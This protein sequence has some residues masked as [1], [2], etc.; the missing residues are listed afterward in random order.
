M[1]MKTKYEDNTTEEMD[2][3][4]MLISRT[5]EEVAHEWGDDTSLVEREQTHVYTDMDAA[6][7]AFHEVLNEEANH[8]SK[9]DESFQHRDKEE[10]DSVFESEAGYDDVQRLEAALY[11]QHLLGRGED[12]P[13]IIALWK[14]HQENDDWDNAGFDSNREFMNMLKEFDFNFSPKTG[15]DNTRALLNKMISDTDWSV[16][17]SI[18]DKV[19][20]LCEPH[21][22]YY[23]KGT[24]QLKI[25]RS[26]TKTMFNWELDTSMTKSWRW[27]QTEEGKKEIAEKEERHNDL[28]TYM[29][30]SGLTSYSVDDKGTYSMWRG[31]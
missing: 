24:I 6:V 16:T 25:A 21:G 13:N 18:G 3:V 14:E 29:G 5:K 11:K 1:K 9:M 4:F 17:L 27:S 20:T 19:R 30:E 23:Y 7:L 8:Y 22:Q 2:I 31:E 10:C 15:L 12:E 28:M 26:I